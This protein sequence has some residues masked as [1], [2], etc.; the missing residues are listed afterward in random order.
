LSESTRSSTPRRRLFAV[1]VIVAI[2]TFPIWVYFGLSMVA[3]TLI[4]LVLLALLLVRTLLMRRTGGLP[5]ALVLIGVAAGVGLLLL[6]DSMVAIRAYPVLV[7]VGLAALFGFSLISPPSAIERIAR[8]AE[9]ELNAAAIAYTRKVTWLWF[10]FFIGNGTVAAWT[11]IY[12]TLDQWTLYNGL[13]SYCL[14][15]FLLAVEFLVRWLV[16][17]RVKA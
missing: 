8:L 6:V 12:G 5:I 14:I 4:V 17:D 15:G 2:A 16:R 10:A 11:A 1:L 7:N 9:G 3:P 13:I